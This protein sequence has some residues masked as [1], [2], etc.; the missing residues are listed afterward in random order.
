MATFSTDELEFIK[1]RGNDECAKTWLGLWDP[2]R[3]IKQEQREFMIDKYEQ[4]RYVNYLHV[5]TV[6]YGMLNDSNVRNR[7]LEVRM[8]LLLIY[9]VKVVRRSKKSMEMGSRMS[10]VRYCP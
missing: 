9:D 6:E 8:K 7:F 1:Q 5:T 3:V 2:K 4:K 10:I